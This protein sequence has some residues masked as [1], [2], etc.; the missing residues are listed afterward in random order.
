VCC[1]T[2]QGHVVAELFQPFD[3]APS[4]VFRLKPVKKV[5]P[6]FV[7]RL[8]ALEHVIRHHTLGRLALL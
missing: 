2:L 1:G 6:S 8:L 3:E 4:G 5:R 7:V